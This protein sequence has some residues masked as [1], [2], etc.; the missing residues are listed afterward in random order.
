[1]KKILLCL[2]TFLGIIFLSG[3][4]NVNVEKVEELLNSM[5]KQK[6]VEKDIEL[7]DEVSSVYTGY[8]YS[9]TKYYIYE[10][11]DNKLLAI[12]YENNIHA[13]NDYDYIITIYNNLGINDDVE[14]LDDTS[15]SEQFYTY[16]D[17]TSTDKNKYIFKEE[18]KY[19]VYEKESLFSTKYNFI[20]KK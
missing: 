5:K 12:S 20:L 7:V 14:Y 8:L 13:K 19:V 18:I 16:K 6:I 4:N 17:G 15:G 3:C 11:N 1:M 9:K 2:L 10:T